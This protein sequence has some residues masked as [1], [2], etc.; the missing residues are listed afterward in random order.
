M[1]LILILGVTLLVVLVCQIYMSLKEKE[2]FSNEALEKGERAFLN[3]QNEY[4]KVRSVGIGAGLLKADPEVN[5]WLKFDDKKDLKSYIPTIGGSQSEMDKKITKCRVLTS[6]DQLEEG[7]Q[8]DCGYCAYDKEFRYG[9]K[10]GPDPDVCPT[11]AWTNNRAKCKELREKDICTNVKSCGDLY[12]EAAD[13][14]GFC[15][16]TG[17]GMVKKEVGDKL[18]PKYSDDVCGGDGFGMLSADKCGQFLKDHPCITPYYLSGPHSAACVSKLWKN[19]QCTNPVLYG[20][21]PQALGES[22]RMGYTEV[23]EIMKNTNTKTRDN[24]YQTAVDNSDLC[25]GNHDNV[26]PCDPKFS[27]Q[28]VPHPVCLKKIILDEGC[29]PKGTGFKKISE[30]VGGSKQHVSDVSKYSQEQGAWDIPGFAYPTGDTTNATDYK[31]TIA[32]VVKLITGA[33]DYGTRLNTSMICLGTTPPPPPPITTGCT[34][35]KL[36]YPLRYEGVVTK[37]VGQDCFIMWTAFTN[38]SNN[39]VVQWGETVTAKQKIERSSKT[40]EQQAEGWGWPG[41]N[42]T[43]QTSLKTTYSKGQLAIKEK[44]GDVKSGCKRT[45]KEA[46]A[47][48]LYRFPPPR[49]CIV[50][51]WTSWSECSRTCGG[52]SQS[53]TRPILYPAKFGGRPC[54]STTK[55]KACAQTPCLNQNFI[56]GGDAAIAPGMT[57]GIYLPRIGRWLCSESN[58]RIGHRTWRYSWEAF[59]V[60]R[61]PDG[62]NLML[63]GAHGGYMGF[64]PPGTTNHYGTIPIRQPPYYSVVF[65]AKTAGPPTSGWSWQRLQF[66]KSGSYW[67]IYN[68]YHK[69]YLQACTNQKG[70]GEPTVGSC[71]QFHIYKIVNGQNIKID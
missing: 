39:S 62:Q 49:D 53:A 52:G 14:C 51:E 55:Y 70:L 13:L 58:G 71:E 10:D 54:P 42:P 41:I 12:G 67:T 40:R 38:V 9:G 5:K 44:C 36:L 11:K 22:I 47:D 27:R 35:T 64:L 63:K 16:T 2:G 6:C 37:M 66:N 69:R 46:V 1:K 29:D 15:P 7:D 45:C 23:G 20:K 56:E 68:P 26:D 25:F 28:G 18:V 17:T 48:V 30:G 32:R 19:S 33:S 61:H 4:W 31:K 59:K 57:I 24:V 65:S 34:V 43:G 8:G 60:L 21:T 50:G 3:K